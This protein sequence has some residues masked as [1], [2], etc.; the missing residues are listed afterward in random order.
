MRHWSVPHR[1]V[2]HINDLERFKD[3]KG[4]KGILRNKKKKRCG[5]GV[6]L[7]V[8]RRGRY[9]V[10]GVRDDGP[11]AAAAG[12]LFL[13]FFTYLF[14]LVRCLLWCLVSWSRSSCTLLCFE[15]CSILL[16]FVTAVTV[17]C[18]RGHL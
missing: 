12:A 18:I 4:I 9:I 15:A 7:T 13:S 11:A 14:L 3:L 5:I 8:D 16:K 6:S 2:Q 1:A 10:T 17:V